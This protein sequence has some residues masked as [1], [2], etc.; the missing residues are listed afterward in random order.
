M[1]PYT[2]QR[3]VCE[4]FAD[5]QATKMTPPVIIIESRRITKQC[6]VQHYSQSL[7]HQIPVIIRLPPLRHQRHH[8]KALHYVPSAESPPSLPHIARSPFFTGRI[9][10]GW[11]TSEAHSPPGVGRFC[12]IL[13]RPA[14]CSELT[15]EICRLPAHCL[16]FIFGVFA[17]VESSRIFLR[18]FP[19]SRR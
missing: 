16:C 3:A 14:L 1:V 6:N 12:C 5:F 8:K 11:H 7:V 2:C 4:A 19:M 18:Y 9:C 10:L 13:L 17:S 15:G